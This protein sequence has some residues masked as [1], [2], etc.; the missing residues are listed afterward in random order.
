MVKELVIVGSQSGVGRTSIAMALISLLEDKIILDCTPSQNLQRFLNSAT[1]NIVEF[2]SDKQAFIELDKCMECGCCIDACKYGAISSD[3]I[4]NELLCEGCGACHFK[5]PQAAIK[6]EK[7]NSA[8]IFE[9]ESSAGVI[10]SA[11]PEVG[12]N[13]NSKLISEIRNNARIRAKKEKKILVVLSSVSLEK[14]DE[15]KFVI[16]VLE[17]S[18][19]SVSEFKKLVPIFAKQK[20]KIMVCINKVDIN[21]EIT[22]EIENICSE[23]ELEIVGKIPYDLTFSRALQEGKSIV[24]YD[25]TS[26]LVAKILDIEENIKGKLNER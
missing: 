5:C 6:L 22:S 11:L 13:Y 23:N 25:R 8:K 2:S 3:F 1:P 15:D 7:I 19:S 18:Y 21:L 16:L 26:S 17:P 14:L 10:I 4:V 20:A 24:E 9:D 12:K